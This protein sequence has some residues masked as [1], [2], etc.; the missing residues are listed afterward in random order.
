MLR[1]IELDA[2][3][4]RQRI[5][6]MAADGDIDSAVLIAAIADVVGICAAMLERSELPG[7]QQSFDSRMDSFIERTRQARERTKR[8]MQL[9]G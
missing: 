6:K 4:V 1:S 9:V 5:L 2:Q 7:H 3:R 8:R